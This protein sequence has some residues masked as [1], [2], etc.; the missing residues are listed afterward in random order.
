[1]RAMS[2]MMWATVGVGTIGVIAGVGLMFAGDWLGRR[3][4]Q[5]L[6]TAVPAPT[7]TPR[8]AAQPAP[9]PS[10]VSP[11]VTP[12]KPEGIL[13]EFQRDPTSP[14]EA[15]IEQAAE[16]I[17]VVSDQERLVDRQQ[18]FKAT[19]GHPFRLLTQTPLV[20]YLAGSQSGLRVSSVADSPWAEKLGLEAGDVVTAVN[21]KPVLDP[22]QVGEITNE[23][24]S[25]PE[26]AVTVQR[27]GQEVHLQY[28]MGP[29]AQAPIGVR[30]P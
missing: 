26:V 7:R 5:A 15:A 21:G 13:A 3:D 1:M 11:T 18:I 30:S 25:A 10:V 9:A 22:Q 16:A 12:A 24:F 17:T 27:A 23:L 28:H 29:S 8:K 6:Q 20:A 14:T 19:D 4:E 2:K